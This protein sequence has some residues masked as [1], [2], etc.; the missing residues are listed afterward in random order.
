MPDASN[1]T[2]YAR[3]LRL[4]PV[5]GT[6]Q[7]VETPDVKTD[8]HQGG[9]TGVRALRGLLLFVLLPT[10]AGMVYFGLIAADRYESE[11][12]FV[13]RMPGMTGAGG[14]LAALMQNAEGGL[15][16]AGMARGTD[17]SY[18]VNDYLESRDALAYVEAH[19]GY[20]KAVE[21]EAADFL[22][23][24]PNFF[25]SN[26]QEGLYRHYRRLMSVSFDRTTG[27]STLRVEA[28]TPAEAQRLATSLLEAA[29]A[30]V[31]RLNERARRD[32]IAFAEAE[33]DRM[34][35]RAGDAQAKLTAFR[36]Q[37]SLI[38][39]THSTL[40]VLEGIARLSQEVALVNV[41]LRELQ[42]G[43]PA[44]P[45]I[46][47]LRNRQAALEA[48]IAAE[49]QKLAGDALS[50]APRIAEYEG[51]M[52]ERE[53]AHRALLAALTA[54]E[55]ARHDATR[56]HVYVEQVAA[57]SLPD[58]AAYPLRVLWCLGIL[59]LSYVVFRIGSLLVDDARRHADP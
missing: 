10:L 7:P 30:L 45:Q 8:A 18:I 52:L 41:Q 43:S 23:R 17:D 54:V 29:E 2:H 6:L 51:L 9:N 58:R 25:T 49:R 28:F 12:R 24:F 31:N 53:F 36:E 42:S 37:E 57:P 50:I 15:Q 27:V 56:Q 40:A 38:D 14:A 1:L 48:Q 32:S 19:A 44:G 20:R 4:K 34:R 11:A 55:M 59:L 46:A 22:W 39:P 13:I 21:N 5:D 33:V 3:L 16:S 26:S 47:A 35:Q